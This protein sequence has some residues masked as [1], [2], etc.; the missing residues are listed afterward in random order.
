MND[1]RA[2]TLALLASRAAGA[3]ICPSEVARAIAPDWRGAMPA[4]HAAV[5]ALLRD[6][7]VQLSWKG[8]PLPT[9]SG[10]Y[11]IARLRD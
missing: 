8:R 6:G 2:A 10:P 1:P 5:D 4:V 3:T 9:R 11:R 7:L